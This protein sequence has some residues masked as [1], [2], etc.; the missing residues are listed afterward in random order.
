MNPH[1]STNLKDALE[2]QLD[3][4]DAEVDSVTGAQ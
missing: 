3:V 2:T 1:T 4:G